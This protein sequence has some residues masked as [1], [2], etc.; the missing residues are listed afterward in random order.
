MVLRAT[1]CGLKMGGILFFLAA[2]VLS[3]Q[4]AD[5]P[6]K[7]TLADSTAPTGI[8]GNGVKILLEEIEK[9]TR[10]RVK[11]EVYWGESLL[12][13]K[14]I[15]AG[16]KDGIV[17][18]GYINP[19][20]YPK[21]MLVHSAFALIPQGPATFKYQSW[22]FFKC[23]EDIP[24]FQRELSAL[25]QTTIHVNTVLSCAVVST[26]PFTKFE[27]FKGK[28]IRA[29]SR[30][31]LGQLK[32]ARAIPVSVPWGDCYMALQTGTIDGVYTNLDGEHRTKL[33]EVAR[34]VYTCKELWVGVPF[35]YTVNNNKWKKLPQ[36][37]QEQLK[38]AGK[39]A[40]LRFSDLFDVEWAKI[41]AEQKKMG[42]VVTPASSADIQKW[43]SMPAIGELQSQW[44]K[45]AQAA[46][47]K[48]A[49]RIMGR[50]KSLA[51][52]AIEREKNKR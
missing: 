36:D 1:K 42:C 51:V 39:A 12:K 11:V 7:L 13:A 27:D 16:V 37:V 24:A 14:E 30:W 18:M 35:L 15:L 5:K 21:E 25:N 38:A 2:F 3:V 52:E 22:Y 4:A 47:L 46:G 41:I 40:S 31:F 50:M 32:G 17:D 43:V 20:Y 8:R 48:D 9:H 34:N 33:D 26:K 44:V 19:N 49:D 29:S 6:I 45:E 10:G 23:F 28:K